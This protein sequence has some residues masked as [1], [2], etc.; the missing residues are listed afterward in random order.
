MAS[1]ESALKPGSDQE[2]ETRINLNNVV[3]NGSSIHHHPAYPKNRTIFASLA[4][5]LLESAFLKLN[6]L[7]TRIVIMSLA[8]VI[9][10][11]LLSRL[12]SDDEDTLQSSG[13]LHPRI[14]TFTSS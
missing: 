5:N 7:K 12:S 8:V 10:L 1:I 2:Q 4:R 11:F 3:N 13:A 6:A 14:S 9:S